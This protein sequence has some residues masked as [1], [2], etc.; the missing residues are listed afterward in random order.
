MRRSQLLPAALLLMQAQG[1]NLVPNGDFE[2]FSQCPDYVSQIDRATGWSRPTDGTSDYFNACLGVPFSMN[3]PDN[4]SG[5]EPARSGNGYAGFYCFYSTTAVT[6]ATDNDHEYVTRALAAPLIPGA[7][8]AVEFFVSLADVSK[9]A[10]NDIGALLSTQAPY[11]ADEFAITA[12]PQVT[13][14][15]LVMLDQKNGWTRIHGCFVAD[16]AFAYITIGN[17]RNGAA[18]VFEEVPTDFPL[19]YYSYYFVD[20]VSVHAIAPPQLGPDINACAAV[21]LAVQDPVDGA[22]YTWSTGEEGVT[23]VA[24]SAGAYSVSTDL[25]GCIM[26]DTIHVHLTE[27]IQ[28]H[29]PNDT[30]AD[31]C[32]HPLL[33]LDPGPL[34]ANASVSWSTGESTAVIAVQQAGTYTVQVSAPDHCPATASILVV[35]DCGSPVFAPNAFTPNNDGINDRWQPLWMANPD[36]ALEFTIYDRWGRVL[37]TSAMDQSAWDGTAHGSPVPDGV[38]AW[39]GRARDRSASMD[40]RISG[41]VCLIR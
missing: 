20:D 10:V 18:T 13:N 31:F 4:Q 6:T 5:Y 27:P 33:V 28:L 26:S 22:T 25:Y 37:F 30:V 19:T 7:T 21:A 1:Q 24:D 2:A 15:S 29:L 35:D 34:P 40:L 41:H 14:S 11:R 12:A 9:Y 38:Y 3:V 39:R 16:S 36:A 23:I 8:Y 17:F 32:A